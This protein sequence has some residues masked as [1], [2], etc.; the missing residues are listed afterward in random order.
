MTQGALFSITFQTAALILL[1]LA[2]ATF[3]HALLGF[4]TASVAMP[5]LLVFDLLDYT[6][7][8]ALVGLVVLLALARMLAAGS[9]RN[10]DMP[11][12][13]SLTVWSLLGVPLGVWILLIA[14]E[15]H[16]KVALGVMVIVASVY[17]LVRPPVRPVAGL[18]RWCG[19][20]AG[21]AGTAC[22]T[23]APPVVVYCASR[24]WDPNVLHAT[25]QLY[26]LP[27]AIIFSVAHLTLG[28]FS[29]G[30]ALL[31]AL[32]GVILWFVTIPLGL[33][34]RHRIPERHLRTGM[35]WCLIV[36]S[37]PLLF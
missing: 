30:I 4:G 6:S 33:K 15:K 37:V 27:V 26:F 36:L 28:Y 19:L 11:A 14:A 24:R 29:G 7:T 18:R 9:W 21:I 5:L 34:L 17:Q 35:H 22:N 8:L 32:A 25:L 3:F 10:A 16:L 20:I 23:N 31:G 12:V 1:I 2:G 13:K